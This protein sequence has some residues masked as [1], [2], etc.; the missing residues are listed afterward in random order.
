MEKLRVGLIW[1]DPDAPA[2]QELD[3]SL[4]I[5]QQDMSYSFDEL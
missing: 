4:M 5:W 3:E 1:V 2:D